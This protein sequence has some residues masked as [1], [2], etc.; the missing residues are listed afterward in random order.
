M[1]SCCHKA[2][3]PIRLIRCLEIHR[4]DFQRLADS[5]RNVALSAFDSGSDCAQNHGPGCVHANIRRIG[6][7]PSASAVLDPLGWGRSDE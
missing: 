4:E 7:S 5:H 1:T 6:C 3:D 2:E